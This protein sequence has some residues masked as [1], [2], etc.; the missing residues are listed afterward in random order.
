VILHAAHAPTETLLQRL[1]ECHDDGAPDLWVWHVGRR[2]AV[3]R[4][5]GTE[6]SLTE[7]AHVRGWVAAHNLSPIT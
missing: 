6:P 4:H 5:D 1:R 7:S 3:Q 2:I